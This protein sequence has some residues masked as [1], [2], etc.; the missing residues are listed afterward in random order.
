[1]AG[2]SSEALA[3]MLGGAVVQHRACNPAP[4][5]RP[6]GRDHCLSETRRN[7]SGVQPS[8]N[9]GGSGRQATMNKIVVTCAMGAYYQFLKTCLSSS[10]RRTDSRTQRRT[11]GLCSSIALDGA[12][13]GKELGHFDALIA[14]QAGQFQRNGHR[15]CARPCGGILRDAESRGALGGQRR[16]RRRRMPLRLVTIF[17]EP[18]PPPPPPRTK[19]SRDSSFDRAPELQAPGVYARWQSAWAS[20]SCFLGRQWPLGRRWRWRQ[21]WR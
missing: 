4:H 2:V 11:L 18:P 10:R 20:A 21:E 15:S 13:A 3:G 1:M 5:Q 6:R 17:K 8:R 7:G 9:S 19:Q 12:K 14:E 16:R